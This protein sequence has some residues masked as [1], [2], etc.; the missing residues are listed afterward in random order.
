MRDFYNLEMVDT[1]TADYTVWRLKARRS[2][3]RETH[4]R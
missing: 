1:N 3:P 4:G 2:S